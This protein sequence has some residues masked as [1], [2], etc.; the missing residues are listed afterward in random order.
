MSCGEPVFDQLP[1]RGLQGLAALCE[2]VREL[3][4]RY[5]AIRLK[6]RGTVRQRSIVAGVHFVVRESAVGPPRQ[7]ML[8]A[9]EVIAQLKAGDGIRAIEPHHEIEPVRLEPASPA[10]PALLQH[11]FNFTQH[12][13]ILNS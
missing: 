1:Q 11:S 8:A 2:Q 4:P 12:P 6:N 10:G 9:P 7:R 13:A 3:V 5:R